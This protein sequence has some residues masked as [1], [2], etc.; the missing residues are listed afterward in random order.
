MLK[1]EGEEMANTELWAY[2]NGKMVRENEAVI[3]LTDR[4]VQWGDAV[5]DSIRTYG[6]KPFQVPYR[7]DRFFRSLLYARVDPGIT[8]EMLRNATDKV[9][10]ANLKLIDA[11]D[12]ITINYYV[13]RGSMEATNG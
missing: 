6:G 9:I 7:I 8:K 3:P 4:G 2:L 5:Y 11:N 13:S 10:A 1:N 12:D